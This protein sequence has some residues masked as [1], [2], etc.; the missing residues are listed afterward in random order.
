[1]GFQVC[2]TTL[3]I[4]GFSDTPWP[5]KEPVLSS[6]AA[7]LSKLSLG[8][9]ERLAEMPEG[10]V[11]GGL[12]FSGE[13]CN[14]YGSWSWYSEYMLLHKA[15]E[16]EVMC[17]HCSDVCWLF[18]PLNILFCI[19]LVKLGHR[20]CV[21]Q[22]SYL[23]GSCLVDRGKPWVFRIQAGQLLATDQD[24]SI[25]PSFIEGT[26]LEIQHSYWTCAIYS[27]F[28]FQWKWELSRAND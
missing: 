5:S 13:W 23:G 20:S 9:N 24:V 26:F 12:C 19:F 18:K 14:F 6:L 28:T 21:R 11:D 27:C 8:E 1:M 25:K 17:S 2:C 10:S 22:L 4:I 7:A 16:N 15:C 3:G